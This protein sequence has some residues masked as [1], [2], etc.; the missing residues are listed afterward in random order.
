[1]HENEACEEGPQRLGMAG[2][3]GPGSRTETDSAEPSQEV[4]DRLKNGI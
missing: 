3:E 4:L 2:G 1:M